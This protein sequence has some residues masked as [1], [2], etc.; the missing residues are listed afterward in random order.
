MATTT[1]LRNGMVI[2]YNG[3]LHRVVEF[4]HV[5]PGNWRAF[6]RLKLRNVDSGRIIDDRVRA[7]SDIDIVIVDKRTMQFLY[8]DGD[9][10]HFMDTETFEQKEVSVDVVGE[11]AQFLKEGENIDILF[12]DDDKI[13]GVELPI[14]VT[15]KVVEAGMAVRGD[16]ATNVNKSAMLET[17]AKIQVPGFVNDGDL[18]RVDTRTGEYMDRTK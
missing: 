11:Q 2:R 13:L 12:Y 4:Q 14:F 18:I 1:D 15:L 10:S 16:T 17:G 3:V 6:V 8:T 7:G 9:T 5:S